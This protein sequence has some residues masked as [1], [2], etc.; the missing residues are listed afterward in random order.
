[1][2]LVLEHDYD[3]ITG[4]VVRREATKPGDGVLFP[5]QH[6]LRGAGFASDLHVFHTRDAARAAIFV[7]HFPKAVSDEF[8]LLRSKFGP[9]ISANFGRRWNGDLT[10][11]VSH[12]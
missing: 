6:R 4:V 2:R 5:V 9:E 12:W 3:V 8:D 7:D 11:G 1:M 10:V